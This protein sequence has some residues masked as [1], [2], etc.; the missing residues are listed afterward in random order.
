MT[1]QEERQYITVENKVRLHAAARILS[2]VLPGAEYGI[3]VEQL[4][5]VTKPLAELLQ[6]V[7][8]LSAGVSPLVANV[9]I[10]GRKMH[11]DAW[12]TVRCGHGYLATPSAED[13]EFLR[14]QVGD[15]RTVIVN[16]TKVWL[17]PDHMETGDGRYQVRLEVVR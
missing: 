9:I 5:Q 16:D 2:D 14:G 15:G 12:V 1:E 4:Q 10:N 11:E 6:Q 3:S 8:N 17:Y 13:W 7:T